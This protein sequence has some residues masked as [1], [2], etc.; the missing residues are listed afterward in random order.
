MSVLSRVF[1][2]PY[3]TE[4]IPSNVRNAHLPLTDDCQPSVLLVHRIACVAAQEEDWASCLEAIDTLLGE[5][6]HHI[7]EALY[8][9]NLTAMF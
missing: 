9:S 8:L 7:Y 3:T 2:P 5:I 6:A 4:L 1:P